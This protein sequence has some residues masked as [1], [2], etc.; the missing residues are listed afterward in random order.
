MKN[1]KNLAIFIFAVISTLVIGISSAEVLSPRYFE[2]QDLSSK[3][4]D[5][6]KNYSIEYTKSR[7]KSISN[8]YD[9]L[10]YKNVSRSDLKDTTLSSSEVDRDD[11]LII[12]IIKSKIEVIQGSVV[13]SRMIGQN[14][15]YVL[16]S[17]NI[18]SG[19]SYETQL[20]KRISSFM[21]TF[22]KLGTEQEIKTAN[23]I[24][25]QE[26]RE[27]DLSFQPRID[28]PRIDPLTLSYPYP[29]PVK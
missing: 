23:E 26:Q 15:N 16:Y 19:V 3:D 11:R 25:I 1:I 2:T 20:S 28:P 4:D 29:E 5:F 9:I 21:D 12:V 10:L 27:K 18:E 7:F 8:N 17:F 6:V 14:F 13:S 22:N 24:A